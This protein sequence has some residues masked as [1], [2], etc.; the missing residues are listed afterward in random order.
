MRLI[1]AGCTISGAVAAMFA[2][3]GCIERTLS[4]QS[5]PPGALVYL[6]DQEVGR[7]PVQRDFLWYGTY[8]VTLRKDGYES[9]KTRATLFPPIYQWLGLDLI[10]EILPISFKDHQTRVYTLR[11]SAPAADPQALVRRGQVLGQQLQSSR[12]AATR[13]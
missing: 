12:H 7:T 13:P 4:V 3:G 8:D 6:N 2:V 11:P 1:W 10:A 5:S 9:L